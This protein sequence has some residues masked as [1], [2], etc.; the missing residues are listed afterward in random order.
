M[1][2]IEKVEVK[3]PIENY[4]VFPSSILRERVYI[5]LMFLTSNLIFDE[6]SLFLVLY[7]PKY[8]KMIVSNLEELFEIDMLH[9]F[10]SF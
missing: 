8:F 2:N 9:V 4:F 10:S 1:C 3:F 6:L 5:F 7:I